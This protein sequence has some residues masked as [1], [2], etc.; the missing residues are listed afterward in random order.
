MARIWL[1]TDFSLFPRW[2]R[3]HEQ[4]EKLNM[5]A[6]LNASAGHEQLLTELLVNY[7]KVMIAFAYTEARKPFG[8]WQKLCACEH[9]R[10]L[11]YLV[12]LRG[13]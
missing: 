13:C 3:Q 4:I 10:T 12:Y 5:Q 7:A 8:A 6:I 11:F 9:R 1:L 2:L